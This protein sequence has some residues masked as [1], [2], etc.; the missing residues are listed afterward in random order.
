MKKQLLK[1]LFNTL[2]ISLIFFKGTTFAQG[3]AA[4]LIKAGTADATI[5]AGAYLNPLFKGIGF[6]MNSGWYNS[7]KT[8]NLGRFDL[9]IQATGALVPTSDRSFDI[10]SLNLSNVRLS[11]PSGSGITP[12][13]FGDDTEGP[14]MVV[15]DNINGTEVE[16]TKFRMPQGSGFNIVPS[17]QVQLTVGLIMNTDLSVRFAPK[18]GSDD[19]GKISS[20][21]I[22]VKKELTSLLPV[23]KIIPFD[24]SLA[25]GY[26]QISYKYDVPKEDQINESN[27]PRNDLNQ[28]LDAKFSGYTIDAILSKKLAVFTPFVSVGYN[29]AKTETGILGKYI[30]RDGIDPATTDPNNPIFLYDTVEDPVAINKTTISGMRANVGFALHLAIFRLYGAYNIGEYQAVTAGIGFGIG[31]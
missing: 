2:I 22:G 8:K 29:T 24:V 19:F 21:G 30:I 1:A 26:N 5:L 11:N 16:L 10:K 3:D 9:R 4:Q 25:F 27:I 14:E 6:G 13:A 7:A 20:W 28:R 17:P 18:V 23:K 12:T 15:T 31:K